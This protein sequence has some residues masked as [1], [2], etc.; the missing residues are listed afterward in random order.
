MQG[1][2]VKMVRDALPVMSNKQSMDVALEMITSIDDPAYAPGLKIIAKQI[3]LHA[4]HLFKTKISSHNQLEAGLVAGGV[5][6]EAHFPPKKT[7]PR[8]P[9]KSDR[10]CH[11]S[12]RI[13][14]GG[15]AQDAPR[16]GHQIGVADVFG[17]LCLVVILVG[18]LM[19][20][21][22]A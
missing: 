6:A 11:A 2:A 13:G 3:D 20:G 14:P 17:L 22:M 5:T 1:M 21:G 8:D 9:N 7:R 16:R 12:G 4:D 19:F 18:V 10:R 15:R